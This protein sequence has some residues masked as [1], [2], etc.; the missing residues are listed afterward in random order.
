MRARTVVL[1][2]VAFGGGVVATLAYAGHKLLDSLSKGDA[3]QADFFDADGNVR[4]NTEDEFNPWDNDPLDMLTV[5]IGPDAGE[6]DDWE[7]DDP[8]D[9]NRLADEE[10]WGEW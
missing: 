1:A 9:W 4:W 7:D 8:D 2:I 6:D 10:Y 3:E 5:V